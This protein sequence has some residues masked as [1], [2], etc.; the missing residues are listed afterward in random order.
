MISP[1]MPHL[2]EELWKKLRYPEVSL[3]VNQKWPTFNPRY[4]EEEKV[5]LV[6]QINGKKKAVLEI[7]KGLSK[8]DTSKIVLQSLKNKTFLENKKIK[9]IIIVP[10]KIA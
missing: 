4:L 9:K 3:V 5:N 1:L 7:D 10:D 6:I 2:A 8:D